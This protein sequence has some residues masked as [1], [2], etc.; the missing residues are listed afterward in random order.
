MKIRNTFVNSTINKD[1]DE[2]LVKN[3]Q[4]IDGENISTTA[5]TDSSGGIITNVLG[6]KKMTNLGIVGGVTIGS[7]SHISKNAVYFFVKGTNFDYVVEWDKDTNVTDVILQSTATTGVLNFNLNNKIEF[8]NIIIGTDDADLL[9]WTDNL[10]PPRIVNIAIAKTYATDGFTSQEISVMKPAPI[11]KPLITPT[12]S[13]DQSEANFIEDKYLSFAYRYKYQDGY[14][15]AISAWSKYAFRPN[16]FDLDFE[17]FE[18]KGMV[19]SY[20]A[21]DISF[22]TGDRDVIGIDL[23]FKESNS[24]DVNVIEKFNKEDE[25]WTNNVTETIEFNNS[26]VYGKLPQKEYYKQFDN[27]PKTAEAQDFIGSRLAYAN[28]KEGYDLKDINGDNVLLDYTLSL[29]SNDVLRDDLPFT[30]TS[31]SYS[32]EGSPLVKA[33]TLFQLNFS[34]FTFTKGKVIVVDFDIN[35]I[36][37]TLPAPTEFIPNSFISSYTYILEDDYTDL[38]DFFTN[39]TFESELEGLFSDYFES[40]I[41][42]EVGE[43]SRISTDFVVT[44]PTSTQ[45]NIQI[46]AFTLVVSTVTKYKYFIDNGTTVYI[47]EASANESLKSNRSYEVCMVFEDEQG[48]MTTAL[49]SEKNTIHIP[50]ANS[51]KQNKISVTI[52]T[53]QKTPSWAKRYRFGIKENKGT[54]EEIYC[55]I[56]YQ[57]GIYRWIKLDGESKNK[58]KEGDELIVKADI[59][60]ALDKVVKTKVLEVKLQESDFIKD[61]KDGNG[62]EI[63]EE[64]GLYF[65][66]SPTNF[67][68]DYGKDDFWYN[69]SDSRASNDRPFSYVD[70]GTTYDEAAPTVPIDLPIVKGSLTQLFFDSYR[71]DRSDAMFKESY[72]A[73]TDYDN[74]E[75][76]YNTYLSTKIFTSNTGEVYSNVSVVRGTY[77]FGIGTYGFGFTPSATGKLYLKVEGIHPGNGSFSTG[78]KGYLTASVNIRS[79]SGFFIFEKENKDL[80]DQVFYL[81]PEKFTIT[82][83]AYQYTDHLLSET[84][85]CYVQGNGAESF[86]IKDAF[87]GKELLLDF[88]PTAVSMDDYKEINR[89]AD[90]TYSDGVLQPSSNI[91]G[92]NSFNLSTANYK[93]DIEKSYG[94]IRLI[95]HRDT[96]LLVVQE[97][98]WSQ[99]FYGKDLLYNADATTNLTVTDNV[100]NTQDTYL[101]EYGI[102]NN[103][104]SFDTYGF[105]CFATDIKRGV[106]LRLDNNGLDEISSKGMTDYFKGLFRDNTITRCVGQYDSLNDEYFLSVF[107]VDSN[108][109][110]KN[111]TWRYSDVHKGWFPRH[112]FAPEDMI[113]MHNEFISFKGGELYLHN[114]TTPTNYN[115]FYG[116]KT[117]SKFSFYF[118]ESPSMRKNFRTID[119]EGTVPCETTLTTE[120]QSGYLNVDNYVNKEG[121]FRG[122][123]RGSES[124]NDTATLSCQ[125]LGTVITKVGNVIT[126]KDTSTANIGDSVYNASMVF[127]AT[128][129]AKTATSLTLSS[130]SLVNVNDFILS[131]KNQ[132]IETSSLLGYYMKVEMEFDKNTLAEIFSVS[133]DLGQ[134]F[135]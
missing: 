129:T 133:G 75:D 50:I 103:A 89:Y 127:I 44:K 79:V 90:I 47:A 101:G 80:E 45:I 117:N 94:A 130:A 66:I 125:G 124:T 48:R 86:K 67:K 8:A 2:R 39:S 19:N 1:V 61:N 98:K 96:N 83:N 71:S 58:V 84:F 77:G 128:I 31:S 82:N 120:F 7:V 111:V 46:P 102:S 15:S 119:I 40:V 100:L 5:T 53:L 21:V 42:I 29:V 91:N 60:G 16:P 113:R 54:W 32:I 63:V 9:S 70:L 34:G 112:N 23:L 62:N 13:I 55:S 30:I 116:V 95:K 132:S 64:A 49:T 24:T 88:T 109:V 135:E 131:V 85:N 118:N 126:L 14:Y 115:T 78:V 108:S 65:K 57:D 51:D 59:S 12:V 43:T 81:T 17:T 72:I 99:V 93:D 4:L 76:F 35:S 26:K 69:K 28:Y 6:N 74:F 56:F 68:I 114:D 105:N 121:V 73:T 87:L 18:N 122:Y 37:L 110:S 25:G 104:S 36:S 20:N 22:N 134:S 27:V 97:N 52:P 106:V 10:N 38:A 107:Y 41:P 92:L 11:E 3:G 123:I 33:S